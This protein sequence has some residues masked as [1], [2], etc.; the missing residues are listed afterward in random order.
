MTCVHYWILESPSAVNVP[1]TCRLCQ[2]KR[3][4]NVREG[5]V[6]DLDAW[7]GT[8]TA[9]SRADPKRGLISRQRGAVAAQA[10]AAKRGLH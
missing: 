6:A 7:T 4:F 2:A 9:A 1:A 5:G 10:A 3:I 8:M